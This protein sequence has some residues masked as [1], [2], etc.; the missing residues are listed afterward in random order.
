[1]DDLD[2]VTA[3]NVQ[4]MQGLAQR[5]TAIR[6]DLVNSDASFG[7]LAWI[8]GKGH[9]AVHMT[10]ACY[11]ALGHPEARGLYDGVGFRPFTRDAPLIKP[12]V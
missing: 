11:G 4:L 9:G 1:V 8:W 3:E 10:V 12:A 7:E 6:P 5:V 2:L